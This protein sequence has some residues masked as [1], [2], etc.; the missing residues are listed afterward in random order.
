L[1]AGPNVTISDNGSGNHTIPAS[2]GTSGGGAFV[3]ASSYAGADVCAKVNDAI[4]A[5]PSNGGTIEIPAGVYP[6]CST[7]I[8][9]TKSGVV[10]RGAGTGYP[11]AVSVGGTTIT[12][13][14]GVT[15]IDITGFSDVVEDVFLL[16]QST[17]AGTD[18]GIR[19]RADSVVLRNVSVKHF[20]R[21]GIVVDGANTGTTGLGADFTRMDQVQATH[22][23]GDGFRW[24][25]PCT[26]NHLGT[27][28]QLNSSLNQGWGYY[29]ACG[30]DNYFLSTHMTNNAAGGWY[31]G[32]SYNTFDNIYAE[33]GQ[34]SSFVIAENQLGVRAR[35]N[36]FGKPDTIANVGPTAAGNAIEYPGPDNWYGSTSFHL[37]DSPGATNNTTYRFAVGFDR[38]MK[39]G[40]GDLMLMDVTHNKHLVDYSPTDN[41]WYQ[42]QRTLFNP[43]ATVAGFN[44]GSYAGDPST[45]VNGDM[46]Y[47]TTLN[48]WRCQENG[49]TVDCIRSSSSSALTSTNGD[50]TPAHTLVD[51]AN[52][53]VSD[54]GA[55]SH[56]LSVPATGAQ[57]DVQCNGGLSAFSACDTT[58]AF[59]LSNAL[60]VPAL[61]VNGASPGATSWVAG[62]GNILTV[63]AAS[64]GFAAPAPG[65]TSYLFKLPGTA[66][67]L[68]SVLTAAP[69]AADGVNELALSFTPIATT[70][71]AN[72]L[73]KTGAGGLI[74]SSLLPATGSSGPVYTHTF[75]G[76]QM[77]TTLGA[78]VIPDATCTGGICPLTT[79]AADAVYRVQAEV[80]ETVPGSTGTCD[81]GVITVNVCYKDFLSGSTYSCTTTA[82]NMQFIALNSAAS[83]SRSVTMTNGA[84]GPTTHFSSTLMTIPAA[85]GTPIQ[86]A[87]SQ[88]T[89]SNC[90]TTPTFAM[91]LQLWGPYSN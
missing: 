74:D 14:S 75:N 65:G 33:R 89:A 8:K 80:V 81:A 45:L 64:A 71:T 36:A 86:A 83:Y 51:G 25:A 22:N 48:K 6:A 31:V 35:F 20:G 43:T 44:V 11:M 56:T 70:N 1:V 46:W 16:S 67:T 52:L 77:S 57:Y 82:P 24:A 87:V 68:S 91:K 7:T 41:Q 49:S 73:V 90:T 78:M 29:I 53:T 28:T 38:F 79:P 34:G 12:M 76:L 42:Q 88:L 63:A 69:A 55:G 5:L 59:Y 47:N 54:S 50:A 27:Y 10:L 19:V 21:Y 30:M 26:D 37:F 18:D 13:A 40:T 72:A 32:A 4:A 58:K 2:G 62:T 23:Y 66:P 39:K 17:A 9:M 84:V 61:G 15:G 60:N 3:N 85:A